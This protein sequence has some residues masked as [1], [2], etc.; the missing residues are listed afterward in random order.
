[1][2]H[3][4]P[5][6]RQGEIMNLSLSNLFQKL[7]SACQ[8]R[9]PVRTAPRAY[10][11]VEP[12]DER[13][14]PTAHVMGDVLGL[15]P[16]PLGGSLT[17]WSETFAKGSATFNA[18]FVDDANL[19]FFKVT[20]QLTPQGGGRNTMTFSGAIPG[21]TVNFKGLVN[22]KTLHARG[23]LERI[24][25]RQILYTRVFGYFQPEPQ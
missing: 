20:G 5:R 25:S 7:T 14:V 17:V 18:S 3:A 16:Y 13:L 8:R 2:A 12:L 10:L 4:T 1:M 11:R 9:S 24:M 22:G 19:A 6:Q 23:R 15:G 21:E